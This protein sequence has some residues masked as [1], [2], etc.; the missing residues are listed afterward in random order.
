M[1][2]DCF[3]LIAVAADECLVAKQSY[4]AGASALKGRSC[5]LNF[6]MQQRK[7]LCLCNP[8]EAHGRGE[9]P[10]RTHITGWPMGGHSRCQ[11]HRLRSIAN[12]SMLD[13]RAWNRSTSSAPAPEAE[14]LLAHPGGLLAQP[15]RLRHYGG[16]LSRSPRL[17]MAV[18]NH[19]QKSFSRARKLLC[20][21]TSNV[22][23]CSNS[24]SSIA[25][26]SVSCIYLHF[27]EIPTSPCSTC[28]NSV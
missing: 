21:M 6:H 1:A 22:S 5:N 10:G 14:R 11:P 4:A 7:C 3:V 8:P 23:A 18:G 17:G 12:A 24:E 9:N 27:S 25:F 20:L 19:M 2:C 13:Q 28:S 26:F 15:K 16:T